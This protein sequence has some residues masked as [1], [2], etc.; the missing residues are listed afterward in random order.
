MLTHPEAHGADSGDAFDVVAPSL[1]GFG[2]SDKPTKLGAIFHVGD[3]WQTLMTEVLGYERFAAHGGDWGSTVT[4]QLARS[5]ARSLVGVHLTD[6]PFWHLFQKPSDL[7][8]DEQRYVD[9]TT[10]W[11]QKDGA[12]AHL[13]SATGVGRPFLQRS[14]LD[15]DAARRTFR[16]AGR[17]RVARRRHPA[18]LS[19]VAKK[20]AA[21]G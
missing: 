20:R 9:A 21:G 17:T 11:Q 16:G 19:S 7:S 14:T 15:R 4:E 18:V 1:P 2:F 13:S 12:Y 5:H 6:V 3:L 8:S 10:K